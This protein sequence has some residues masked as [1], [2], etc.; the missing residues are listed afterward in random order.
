MTSPTPGLVGIALDGF[1]QA[2]VRLAHC[3]TETTNLYA[4]TVPVM[5]SAY[6]ARTLDEQ[7]TNADPAYKDARLRPAGTVVRAVQ[8]LRN[9]STHALP[10]TVRA[11]GGLTMPITLPLT[12]QPVSV[13]WLPADE[14]PPENPKYASP[15][16]RQAYNDT[17]AHRPLLE[18]LEDV[19]QWFTTERNR[20]GSVL[21]GV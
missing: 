4:V 11:I 17:F 7:L 18:P 13:H 14:L 20:T 21:A 16:G 5:E 12:L 8:W 15:K 6:W 1:T 10:L 3:L 9:Q 2:R 19:A